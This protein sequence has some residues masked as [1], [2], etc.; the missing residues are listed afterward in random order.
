[1]KLPIYIVDAFTSKVFNGNPAAVCPLESWLDDNVMQNIAMENN[2]SE[3][4]FFVKENDHYKIRWMTPT[5]EIPL[6]G[7]ATLA[8]SFIIFNYFEKDKNEIKFQSKSGELIITRK[9]DLITLNF[10]ANKPEPIETPKEIINALKATPKETLFNKSYLAIFD[11][12]EEIR[13]MKPDIRALKNIYKMGIIISAKGNNS[14]FV[15]RFFIPSAG[16][17][18]DPVTGFAHTLL[19]P[20]WSEKLN[21]KE[22]H[23]FQVS[24]RGGE[25]FLKD[26]DDRANI[27][28]QAV[29]YSEGSI[30]LDL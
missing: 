28:G 2:L 6:C 10:P 26:L 15:S 17:D 1:M 11:S 9:N 7:H 21:K 4:A 8:S 5:V 13:E 29:L 3:T 16:I 25:L 14:D 27:S 30:F 24:Q 22:L 19:T 20:Y 23:A 18:E 12:E